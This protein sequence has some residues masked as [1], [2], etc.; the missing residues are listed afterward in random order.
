MHFCEKSAHSGSFASCISHDFG[1]IP[2]EDGAA[3][4]RASGRFP[5]ERGWACYSFRM[6]IIESG[7]I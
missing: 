2:D 1:E 7:G 3:S 5:F 4:E 6:G